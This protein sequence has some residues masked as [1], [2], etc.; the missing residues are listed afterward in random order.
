[1]T[2][3]VRFTFSITLAIVY[4][5]PEQVTPS[6]VWCRSPAFSPFTRVSIAFGWSPAG[7][8]EETIFKAI[9]TLYQNRVTRARKRAMVAAVWAAEKEQQWHTKRTRTV[10]VNSPSTRKSSCSRMRQLK[11]VSEKPQRRS[12]RWRQMSVG[13]RQR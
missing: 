3:V 11:N 10:G 7:L 5:F 6:S 4:V 8:Y 13:L 1:M 2:S 12:A 9:G